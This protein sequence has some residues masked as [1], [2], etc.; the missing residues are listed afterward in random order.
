MNLDIFKKSDPSG[1]M[2]KESYLFKNHIEEYN[3]IIEYCELNSIFNVL[4]KEKVYLCLHNLKKI[5]ICKNPNCN[6]NVRFKNSTIGYLEYCSNKCISSDPNIKKRKEEKSF[7]KYGTK[8]PA[9]SKEIKEKIIKTNQKIYGA[10]S[11]MCL[12]ETQEKSKQTLLKNYGV[13]NPGKS[14]EILKKRTESFKLSDYKKNFKKTSLKKYGVDHPWMNNEIHKKTEISSINTRNNNTLKSILRMIGTYKLIDMSYIT[15]DA[16]IECNKNHKFISTRDFIYN[17]Y[18]IKSEICTICNPIGDHKSGAEISII[19]Y[20]KEIY[21]NHIIE[22]DRDVIKPFE[23]DIYLPELKIGFEYNGLWYHSSEY[24]KS[25][26]HQ[27][28]QK[29]AKESNIKLITIWEDEWIYRNDAA[30]SF[31]FNKLNKT[32]NK[33]YARKCEIKLIEKEESDMFLNSNHLSGKTNSSVRISLKYKNEI[34]CLITFSK[35]GLGWELD[36]FCNKNY[37]QVIGGFSRIL[38]SF[39]KQFNPSYIITY[40]DNMVSD[41]EIYEKNGFKLIGELSPSYT[42]LISKIRKHR[43]SEIKSDKLYPK[44]YNAGNKKWILKL[45]LES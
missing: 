17:R 39:I 10:N 35:K 43:F 31:I 25:N 22:N 11:A 7:E 44:I 18:R 27:L 24:R 38:K 15:G 9:Q 45:P 26:Y 32:P 4:F 30:K 28:K 1:R 5:P 14:P 8:S 13:D 20:I 29:K 3:Y 34:L 40:S 19:K 12:K 41:G 36:R 6:N 16:L 21:D 37:T 33:T 42:L 2:S 23:I